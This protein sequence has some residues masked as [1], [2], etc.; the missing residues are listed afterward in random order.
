MNSRVCKYTVHT[1]PCFFFYTS[2][3]GGACAHVNVFSNANTADK[4][5]FC[6]FLHH[7]HVLCVWTLVGA[8]VLYVWICTK[9]V[10]VSGYALV[11]GGML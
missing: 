5:I 11:F 1:A 4:G 8:H 10:F 7:M 3:R 2:Y 6:I 9:F